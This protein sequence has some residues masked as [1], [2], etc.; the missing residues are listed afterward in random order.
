MG[1]G[2]HIEVVASG[3]VV[4]VDVAGRKVFVGG[5]SWLAVIVNCDDDQFV[6]FFLAGYIILL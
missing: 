1:C 4:E 2:Y 3:V 6:V 5:C